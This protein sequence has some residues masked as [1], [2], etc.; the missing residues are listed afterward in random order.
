L[1]TGDRRAYTS[2]AT[3]QQAKG[4]ERINVTFHPTEKRP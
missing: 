4:F 1:T 2:L 3:A